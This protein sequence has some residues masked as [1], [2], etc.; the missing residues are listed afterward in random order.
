MRFG[1]R[2]HS[3]TDIE[4]VAEAGFACAEI[5]L[6]SPERKE[7]EEDSEEL[8]A[9]GWKTAF[10]LRLPSPQGVD[11]PGIGALHLFKKLQAMG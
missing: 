8:A 2:V 1:A 9:F 11:M 6:N 10:L 5:N 3:P 7:T 4:F